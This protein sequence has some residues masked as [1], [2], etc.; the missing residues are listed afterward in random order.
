MENLLNSVDPQLVLL[1][2]AIAVVV[3]AFNLL[4]KILRESFGQVVALVA[5]VLV[6]NYA[7]DIG[8]RQLWF[9][10]SHLPTLVMRFVQSLG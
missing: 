3:L 8:P 9:E 7:F 2:A 6:L 5:I 4:G 1:V 10:I